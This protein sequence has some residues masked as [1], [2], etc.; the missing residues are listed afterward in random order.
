MSVIG[1][2]PQYAK[3][4]KLD[5]I[6]G[7]GNTSYTLLYNGNQQSTLIAEQ[8]LVSVNGIIQNPNSAFTLSGSTIV[9]AEAIDS[10]DTI[11]FITVIGESH[12]VATVSDNTITSDKLA[13]SLALTNTPVRVNK[14]N[15]SVSFTLDSNQN[16]M[17]AGP[18]SID[19]GVS[20]VLYGSF[21][22]V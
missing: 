2:S 16:A 4:Y 9:F 19:S 3:L 1:N 5:A 14:N 21:T 13:N 20:V 10:T 17:A 8:L 22:I 12:S 6:L 15:I 18:L 7:T 11:D